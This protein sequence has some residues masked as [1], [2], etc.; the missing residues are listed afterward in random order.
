M[1]VR[2]VDMFL[3]FIGI[4]FISVGGSAALTALGSLIYHVVAVYSPLAILFSAL[5]F[6]AG[7]AVFWIG[8]HLMVGKSCREW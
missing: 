3:L 5:V 8:T 2:M 4:L 7:V 6:L 1:V